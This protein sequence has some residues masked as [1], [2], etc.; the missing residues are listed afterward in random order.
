M[1]RSP[2]VGFIILA[3]F[4]GGLAFVYGFAYGLQ[5]VVD[6]VLS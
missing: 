5:W 3:E 2:S 1:F 6:H 4:V